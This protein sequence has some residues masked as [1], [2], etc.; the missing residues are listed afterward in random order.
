MIRKWH[1]SNGRLLAYTIRGHAT[2]QTYLVYIVDERFWLYAPGDWGSH[3][4]MEWLQLG[5][6]RREITAPWPW[7]SR[8]R[9]QRIVAKA[10]RRVARAMRGIYRANSFA[11]RQEP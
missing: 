2:G 7:W 8:R 6:N 1:D 3:G 9:A 11:Q 4:P 5:L 10:E